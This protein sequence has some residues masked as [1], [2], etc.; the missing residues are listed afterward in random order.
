MV[1]WAEEGYRCRST[2][3]SL[4]GQLF[5]YFQLFVY[6]WADWTCQTVSERGLRF[7]PLCQKDPL[8][9]DDHHYEDYHGTG[10]KF[11]LGERHL[12]FYSSAATVCAQKWEQPKLEF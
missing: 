3:Y 6:R 1:M 4:L 2:I 12:L 10:L 7:R 8:D 11:R 5:A 9:D